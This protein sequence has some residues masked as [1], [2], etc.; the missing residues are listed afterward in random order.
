MIPPITVIE[1]TVQWAAQSQG[2]SPCSARAA[3]WAP[4]PGKDGVTTADSSRLAPALS[5]GSGRCEPD[6]QHPQTQTVRGSV[7]VRV[8]DRAFPLLIPPVSSSAEW[9]R[10]QDMHLVKTASLASCFA[11]RLDACSSCVVA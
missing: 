8:T 6:P 7:R 2:P 4:S 9:S 10:V 3:V 11:F 5:R 1:C